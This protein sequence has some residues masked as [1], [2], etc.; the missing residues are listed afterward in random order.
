MNGRRS[1]RR[2]HRPRRPQLP[3]Q[4]GDH[5]VYGRLPPSRET[6]EAH[7]RACAEWDAKYGEEFAA[8]KLARATNLKTV[9]VFVALAL[10]VIGVLMKAQ[11]WA[12]SL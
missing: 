7:R 2:A 8:E 10:W 3:F 6:E 12:V 11:L 5:K 9:V 1:E 4:Y